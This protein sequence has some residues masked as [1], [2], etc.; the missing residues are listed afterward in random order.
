MPPEPCCWSPAS[1]DYWRNT[2][3]CPRGFATGGLRTSGASGMSACSRGSG[4]SVRALPGVRVSRR[5]RYGVQL[6]MSSDDG[7]DEGS[8]RDLNRCWEHQY[9]VLH[10]SLGLRARHNLNTQRARRLQTLLNEAI[11]KVIGR[12]TTLLL[13]F[14]KIPWICTGSDIEGSFDLTKALQPSVGTLSMAWVPGGAGRLR[15]GRKNAGPDWCS[16]GRGRRRGG[17]CTARLGGNRS[18]AMAHRPVRG[19]RP[20]PRPRVQLPPWRCRFCG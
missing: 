3:A 1:F 9:C 18:P 5:S 14:D 4:A 13:I 20:P 12:K 17:G 8:Q 19:Q 11:E 15:V 2:V 10:P 7:A 6:R 16:A